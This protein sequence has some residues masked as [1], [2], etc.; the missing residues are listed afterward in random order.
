MR[1]G[2]R[3]HLQPTESAGVSYD[4]YIPE[5]IRYCSLDQQTEL[6]QQNPQGMISIS[7]DT[8]HNAEPFYDAAWGLCTR[9]ILRPG[10]VFPSTNFERAPVIGACFFLTD[11]G[12]KWLQ[13]PSLSDANPMEYARFAQLLSRHNAR[14]GDAYRLRASEAVRCYEGHTYFACCAMCGAGAESVLLTLATAKIGEAE[15]LRTYQQSGGRGRIR[16]RLIGHARAE[17]QASF[18]SYLQLL[19]YW[20]DESAHGVARSIGE[21]EAFTSLALLLRR[22]VR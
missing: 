16:N 12:K 22:R 17:M 7:V 3:R 19:N 20:R 1:R 15:A 21:E 6:R 8:N 9:G 5:V 10:A 14:F 11:Y 13:N 18:D 4:L 2:G